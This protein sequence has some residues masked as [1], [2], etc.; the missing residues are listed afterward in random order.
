MKA[1]LHRELLVMRSEDLRVREE[2][3][4]SGAIGGY[5]PRMEEVHQRNARRLR[6]L[7]DLHGWPAEVRSRASGHRTRKVGTEL[8]RVAAM[9]EK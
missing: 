6:E 2:G 3:I 5:D 4:A 1:D 9:A 7:I 8:Q